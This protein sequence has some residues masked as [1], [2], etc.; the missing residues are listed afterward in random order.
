MAKKKRF[1]GVGCFFAKVLLSCITGFLVLGCGYHLQS[2]EKPMGIDIS[3]VAI[4]LMEST[5]SSLGFE[6]DFT[7]IIREE[8]VSHSKV[9]LVSKENASYILV[10]KI[11]EIKT[12]ALGYDLLKRDRRGEEYTYEITDSRRMYIELDAKLL[13]R[14]TGNVIWSEKGMKERAYYDVTSD[15]M[16]NRYN[17]REAIRKMARRFAERMFLKTMER[18]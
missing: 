3:S 15:P 5:S 2:G 1:F 14:S 10:G 16:A 9:P 6:S 11:V 12:K 17:Q 7:R 8:F 4:P 18:F 13:E